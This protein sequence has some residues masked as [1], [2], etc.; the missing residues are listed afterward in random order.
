MFCKWKDSLS[1]GWYNDLME[2]PQ[3]DAF[4][5]KTH[6]ITKYD[7]WRAQYIFYTYRDVRVA[8]V[9]SLYKFNQPIT[10]ESI[11][12]KIRE[13]QIAK[14]VCHSLIKYEDL[15]ENANSYIESLAQVLEIEINSEDIHKKA[16]ELQSPSTLASNSYSKTTLLHKNHFTYTEDDSWRKIIPEELKVKINNEFSWWFRECGYPLK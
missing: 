7:C 11:E 5:L 1:S 4:L 16:F 9:S 13:Y 3:G 8:A 14:K 15:L 2:M 6:K 12:N 10:I